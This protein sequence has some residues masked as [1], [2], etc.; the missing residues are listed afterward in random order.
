[1]YKDKYTKNVKKITSGDRKGQ[2]IGCA[3]HPHNYYFQVLSENGIINFL[4]LTFFYFYLL[5]KILMHTYFKFIKRK[6]LFKQYG[7]LDLFILLCFTLANST[8]GSIFSSWI[9]STLFLPMGF[10]IHNY[11]N[12]NEF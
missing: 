6:K 3:N 1:M 4:L 5:K 12:K 9:A 8:N 7:S 2:S 11:A 10:L